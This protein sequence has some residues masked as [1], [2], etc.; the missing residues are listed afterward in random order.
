MNDSDMLSAAVEQARKS[1]DEGGIPIGA[2][3]V[4]DGNVLGTGHN[5]RVQANSVIHHGETNCLENIGR[6][7]ATTYAKSTIITTLSPC[8]MCTGA[9]LLYK[10]PRV[11]IGDNQNF[12][13]GE[14]LLRENGVEVE[15]LNDAECIEMMG[16][17]IANNSDLWHEDIGV[18]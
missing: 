6:L 10:I 14:D 7:T 4:V 12:Y 5:M 8:M 18:E 2:A 9:I 1:L 11:I 3:L 17:F 16:E 13:G 15:V